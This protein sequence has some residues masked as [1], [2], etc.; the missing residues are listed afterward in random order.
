MGH[1]L[2]C[3]D[4]GPRRQGGAQQRN[5]TRQE[6]VWRGLG[7]VLLLRVPLAFF[8]LF[9]FIDSIERD[10]E[11]RV[12]TPERF[13]L[14][15]GLCQLCHPRHE[16]HTQRGS[17]DEIQWKCGGNEC[18]QTSGA[19]L[20]SGRPPARFRPC[21]ALFLSIHSMVRKNLNAVGRSVSSSRQ[22]LPLLP[23]VQGGEG[24]GIL[25]RLYSRL[26][27]PSFGLILSRLGGRVQ[28][29]SCPFYRVFGDDLRFGRR[30]YDRRVMGCSGGRRHRADHGAA[31]RQPLAERQTSL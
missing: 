19:V 7:A 25:Y 3:Q 1:G 29:L 20:G 28:H 9:H 5:T 18:L 10:R 6:R 11:N 4:G 14:S 27:S 8:R 16:G 31:S 12:F 22:P 17:A 15:I 24:R 2:R 13:S 30:F 21:P 23:S 26:V